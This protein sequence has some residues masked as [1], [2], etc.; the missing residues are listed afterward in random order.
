M[1]ARWTRSAAKLPLL[2]A[3]VRED[4]ALDLALVERQNAGVRVIMIAS[5]GCN[6]AA[7]AA[8]PRVESLHL[9]DANPA[10][11]ALARLKLF[12]LRTADPDERMAVLGHRPTRQ[13][14]RG[15]L[16]ENAA[17]GAGIDPAALGDRDLLARVGA[18]R[19]GRYECLFAELRRLLGRAGDALESVLSTRDAGSRRSAVAPD[20]PLGRALDHALAGA[21]ATRDIVRVFGT[22]ATRNPRIPFERHFAARLRMAV[23]RWGLGGNPYLDQVLLGRF[24]GTAY[25]WLLAE[26]TR[27]MPRV[28]W[29]VASIQQALIEAHKG[30]FDLVHLSNIV[31]WLDPESAQR[32]L[33]L[34]ARALAPDGLLILRQLNSRIDVAA[35]GG[36][37]E[38]DFPLARALHRSD[39]SFFYQRV[40]V[41]RRR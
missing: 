20:A 8:S 4:P 1:F 11:I 33:A 32:T 22:A 12:L 16:L 14:A 25:P 34:S 35:L 3:Q 9:V 23:G 18:D 15:R 29:Q 39:R 6:A 40:H 2:F 30:S 36:E 28:S 19:A 38:W 26:A 24:A 10:Q 41:G 7:L 37:I 31:D 27:S 21:F 17:R 5:G 13:V